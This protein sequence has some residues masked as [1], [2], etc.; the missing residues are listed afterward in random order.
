MAASSV[1]QKLQI[2]GGNR[3]A[4]I[5]V[6]GDYGEIVGSLPEGITLSE[7]TAGEFDVVHGFFTMHA[8]LA[9]RLEE[10]KLAMGAT[11]ILWISYPKRSTKIETDLNRDILRSYLGKNGLRAIS[12]ISVDNTWSAMRLKKIS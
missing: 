6:P 5:S 10:L 2:K 12:L 4:I 11:G 8:E 7:G 1:A 9:D 3:V